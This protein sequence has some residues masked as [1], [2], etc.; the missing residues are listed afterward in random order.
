MMEIW[1]DVVGYEGDYEASN[2]GNERRY[3]HSRKHKPH[4]KVLK[5]K[6]SLQGYCLVGLSLKNSIKQKRV[7][8]LVAEA[9]IPNSDG[10]P[11]VNHI[12]GC[13]TN[14][15]V[16]NLEWCTG[17]ENMLHAHRTGLFPSMSKGT[18]ICDE[19]G[20]TAKNVYDMQNKLIALKLTNCTS[21]SKISAVINGKR[22]S[23]LGMTFRR[24]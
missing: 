23:Y 22:N 13:K 11:Q 15:K 24:E 14:N 2:L 8:R 10:K 7:H 17:K 21:A 19:L 6:I 12:D 9:F 18:V 16:E 20:I 3:Y 4:Y 1:K 5:Q